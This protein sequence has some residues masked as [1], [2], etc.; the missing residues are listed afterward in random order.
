MADGMHGTAEIRL[1]LPTEKMIARKGG[2]V[3]W[4]V[5]NQPEK[6]NAMSVEMWQ[7]VE[8]IAAD[9]AADDAVRVVVLIGAG[10]KAF[11][12]GADISQFEKL[13]S[14]AEAQAEY[15]RLV[16]PGRA[17]LAALEK[18]TIAMIQGY[19]IGGGMGI[20]VGCDIR[21]ASED[22]RFAIPAAKLGLAYAAA[23]LKRL[24]DLVGPA[25]AKEIMFTG[26]QYDAAEALRIGLVNR[27]VPAAELEATVAELAGTIA[28]NAPLTVH[29]SRVTINEV[30]KDPAERDTAKLAAVFRAC[31]DSADY[32]EGRRAFLEKRRP[33]FT[34]L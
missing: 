30:L 16:S 25:Q 8:T 4:I 14:D 17:A 27:V 18:P 34:G 19:C 3:G 7:A 20:A 29:A 13:R 12:S 31:F 24:V 33:V 1:T 11:V 2:G 5:F 9:F 32:R 23:G 28:A 26:R 22:S 21:I 10:G 15:D 6:R